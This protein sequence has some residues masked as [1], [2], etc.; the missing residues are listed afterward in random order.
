[1]LKELPKTPGQSAP[2]REE[3]LVLPGF[4]PESLAGRP[5]VKIAPRKRFLKAGDNASHPLTMRMREL[6]TKLQLT[7]TQLVKELNDYEREHQSHNFH[8]RAAPGT[9][10]WMPLTPMLMS[11][12]L[13]GW[14]TQEPYM[15]LMEKRL[16]SLYKFK[17]S[18]GKIALQ[19]D[20]RTIM[21]GW[22]AKLGIDPEDTKNSPTRQLARMIAPY[23]KRPVLAA[24]SGKFHLGLIEGDQR[25]CTITDA[26]KVT[27][28]VALNPQEPILVQGGQSVR[29]GEVL[30][31]SVLMQ[32]VKVGDKSVLTHEPSVNHTTFFRW[33]SA[34][35]MPR[36]IKTIELVQAAVEE[37]A[38]RVGKAGSRRTR[39]KSET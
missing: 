31:Y 29:V 12:Y 39:T 13:Q 19:D 16:T 36:S 20:I 1:M 9:P 3:G 17:A 27:H 21:N 25:F 34:N 24:V 35:K 5:N 14:V 11:S 18:K 33:Y 4:R 38:R 30:Q 2:V 6:K 8:G 32:T 37:A 15:A 7:T 28:L 26:E 22:Y 23:Y 10:P